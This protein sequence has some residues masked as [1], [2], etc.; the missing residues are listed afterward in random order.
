MLPLHRS[1]IIKPLAQ[2]IIQGQWQC[3]AFCLYVRIPVKLFLTPCPPWTSSIQS[4]PLTCPAPK[5]GCF[6]PNNVFHP[7]LISLSLSCILHETRDLKAWCVPT[8]CSHW[9]ITSLRELAKFLTLPFPLQLSTRAHDSTAV[10]Q[11]GHFLLYFASLCIW[12][13]YGRHWLY[14]S[15]VCSPI[16]SETFLVYPSTLPTPSPMPT[17]RTDLHPKCATLQI[18]TFFATYLLVYPKSDVFCHIRWQ[19]ALSNV[20]GQGLQWKHALFWQ[21]FTC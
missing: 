9:S 5:T 12:P 18:C 19:F 2:L 6:F 13:R 11:L 3:T 21:Y 10:P 17:P 4:Y 20:H 15:P 1:L 8:L 7:D 14:W 16:L